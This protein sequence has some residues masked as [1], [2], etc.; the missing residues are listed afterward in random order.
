MEKLLN[1]G[2]VNR[3]RHCVHLTRLSYL[4]LCQLGLLMTDMGCVQ[5]REYFDPALLELGNAP[6]ARAD[7]S[8]FEESNTQ[9]P[10]KYRVDILL[11]DQFIETR[12]VDFTLVKMPAATK[13]CSLALIRV[14]WNSWVSR[15]RHSQGWPR[16]VAP[17]YQRPF[18]RPRQ[19]FALVN[20]SLTSAFHRPRWPGRRADMCHQ[21]SGTRVFPPCWPTTALAVLTAGQPMTMATATTV[22][23]KFA[24]WIEYRPLAVTQ[25]LNLGARQ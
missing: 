3:T 10:G 14:S 4:I 13:A 25:L 19:R 9:A 18:L 21:N 20:S 5:A 16:T 17:T 12:E 8:V 2:Y 11:N 1:K 6:Q 23:F 15:W 24:Q 7:L 22:T